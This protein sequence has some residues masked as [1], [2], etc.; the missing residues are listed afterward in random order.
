MKVTESTA[1]AELVAANEGSR[2]GIWLKQLLEC[3]RFLVKPVV[4]YVDN[5]STLQIASHPTSHKRTKHLDIT[6]LKIRE[7]VEERK[8]ELFYIKSEQNIADMFTKSLGRTKFEY[9]VR[10][11]GLVKTSTSDSE[12][13]GSMRTTNSE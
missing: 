2:D 7:Y 13:E 9:F 10:Q 6:L 1:E 11:L 5:K 12:L 4:V 8:I 3:M